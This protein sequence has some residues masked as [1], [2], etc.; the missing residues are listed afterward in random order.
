MSTFLFYDLE[1]S[2]LNPAFD[3]ILQFAAIRT[4]ENFQELSRHERRIRLRPDIIPSPGALLTTDVSVFDALTSGDNEY[5]VIRE[6]HALLNEPNSV[7]IGYNSLSFDD[8]FLRFAFYRNLLPPY[9]HQWKNGCQRLDIFPIAVLYWLQGS[10]L[11]NWPVVDGKPTLR[12]EH[13]S[14]ENNL[15][16]GQAH[17]ALVDVEA[18]VELA[19]RLRQNQ[20]LWSDCLRFFDKNSFTDRLKQLPAFMEHPSALLIHGKYG[21]GQSC[22]IPA[23]YLAETGARSVWLR[24]DQPGLRQTNLMDIA[25]MTWVVRKKAGEPPFVMPPEPHQLSEERRAITRDNLKWLQAHPEMLAAIAKHY[26]QSTFLDGEKPDADAAL[27]TN[28]FQSKQTEARCHQFH[29]ADLAG[30]MAL[31]P[32]FQDETTKT[33]ATRLLC[34]NDGLSYR[35][36]A[37][38][39]YLQRVGDDN[40]PLQDFRG[41]SRLTPNTAL[42]EIKIKRQDIL[43]LRQQEILDDLEQYIRYQFLFTNQHRTN[44][45]TQ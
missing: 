12:L 38:V 11:L 27:Y 26:Q 21:Y 30:K 13:L 29:H 7:N 40:Q 44:R 34:R 15:A 20:T 4:D 3:Q 9:T 22:Q 32:Q 41:D 10:P 6:I 31:L 45:L 2:G 42:E 39:A 17:D 33:L 23:L 5:D 1:T 35:Y 37:Y 36:P 14:R 16:D 8:Q 25:K 18:T 24:L 19:R 28:G 43:T